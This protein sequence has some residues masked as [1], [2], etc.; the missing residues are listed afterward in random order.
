[1]ISKNAII[2]SNYMF[3]KVYCETFFSFFSFEIW[4]K[5]SHLL[6]IVYALIWTL[7]CNLG[8][9]TL[10]SHA[11]R[12]LKNKG[13]GYCLLHCR[14]KLNIRWAADVGGMRKLDFNHIISCQSHI[15]LLTHSQYTLTQILRCNSF[16]NI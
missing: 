9:W 6:Q 12:L 2:F 11:F 10:F 14:F 1:M 8:L 15:L 13:Y 16:F 4:P 5:N 3:G 7:L